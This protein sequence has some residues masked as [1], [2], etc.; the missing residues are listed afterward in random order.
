MFR[1]LKLPVQKNISLSHQRK[2]NTLKPNIF[3]ARRKNKLKGKHS[4]VS[5]HKALQMHNEAKFSGKIS[6][7]SSIHGLYL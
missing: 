1:L 3:Q 2:L 5:E 6:G 4:Y 7:Q